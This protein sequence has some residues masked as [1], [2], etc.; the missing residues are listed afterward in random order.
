MRDSFDAFHFHHYH[1]DPNYILT[2]QSLDA[3]LQIFPPLRS[4][5]SHSARCFP[6]RIRGRP[7][8][9][10]TFLRDPTATLISLLR[11]TKREFHNLSPQAT[12]AWPKNTPELKLRDLAAAYLDGYPPDYEYSP[13]SRFF[14]PPVFAKQAG[15][16][17][18]D[19]YGSSCPVLARLVLN[20]FV[21]VG[22]VDDF[23]RSLKVLWAK[24]WQLG[25]PLDISKAPRENRA[26]S[27]ER[28]S[29]LHAGDRVG[30]RVLQAT[31]SDKE[32]YQHFRKALSADFALFRSRGAG[33][34]HPNAA[35]DEPIEKIALAEF[36][37]GSGHASAAK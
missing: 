13:I 6:Q 11:Y 10:F 18:G 24:M 2:P 1:P 28:L 32:L 9:Y 23:M 7:L 33:A 26:R 31:A 37:R 25:V 19:E 17:F 4:I 8:R 5:S 35:G 29:W 3:L 30:A 12:R 14:C 21:C 27:H 34:F 22:I 36:Q 20:E 16:D 15:V